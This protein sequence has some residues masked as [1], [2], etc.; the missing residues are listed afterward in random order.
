ME[1][2]RYAC[3]AS[4]IGCLLKALLRDL[5]P[6]AE[7]AEGRSMNEAM[8][9]RSWASCRSRGARA[10]PKL[11]LWGTG[12]CGAWAQAWHLGGVA[13]EASGRPPSVKTDMAMWMSPLCDSRRHK[14]APNLT[15]RRFFGSF[16]EPSC[17]ACAKGVG[18]DGLW[19]SCFQ[20]QGK[21]SSPA[22]FGTTAVG[23]F[24]SR[25]ISIRNS[26]F[27]TRGS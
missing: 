25:N 2:I 9:A 20:A 13:G 3:E 5:S 16:R 6:G 22:N 18:G 23:F 1:Q 10:Q 8:L 15:C 24:R 11:C 7:G 4:R 12:V 17:H 27:C 21:S 19:E 14:G 26:L